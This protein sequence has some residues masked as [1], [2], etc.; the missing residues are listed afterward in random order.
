M[1]RLLE[2]NAMTQSE[3]PRRMNPGQGREL[4]AAALSIGALNGA[5]WRLRRTRHLLI[6]SETSGTGG[7]LRV[8]VLSSLPPSLLKGLLCIA[9]RIR[10]SMN[11]AVFWV[12]P[13]A[14]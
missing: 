1:S 4:R 5:R 7:L 8:G 12:T 6:D 10:W 2:R 11:H 14:R 9:R 13:T 3:V